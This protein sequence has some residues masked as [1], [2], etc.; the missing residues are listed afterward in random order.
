MNSSLRTI[1]VVNVRWHNATAWYGL[2]LARLLTNAGHKTL[3]LGL[4]NTESYGR[5][6]DLGLSPTA[7]PLNTA[8]PLELIAL[9]H[10][11]SALLSTF[12][13]HI[14]NC[15]RGENFFLWGLLKQSHSF[16]LVRTRGDQRLPRNTLPNRLLHQR[17]ADAL[18]ATNSRMATHFATALQVEPSH[19]HTIYGGVDT[20]HFAFD[21]AARERIRAQYNYGPNDHVVGLLGRF[22]EVKGQR[23]LIAAIAPLIHQNLPIHVLLIGFPTA[24]SQQAV[25]GWIAEANLGH[26]VRITGKVADVPAH[27]AALDTGVVASLWSET[28]ARAALEIMAARRP[29]ISTSVGVM[30]D[31]L[32]PEALCP[33]ADVPALTALVRRAVESP[34]WAQNLVEE[35][36]LRMK[37]LDSQ[38]FLQQTMSVY[39]KIQGSAD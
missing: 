2:E 6:Q 28:I 22:D 9:Y 11:L 26:R 16:K 10:R 20:S 27:L 4:P 21:P 35:Q 14:V 39:E 3:V 24:T 1:Q 15:H 12:K 36:N 13:P 23:E 33:P 8:N 17:V 7:L 18:V 25:E 5:A 34:E 37:T 29:L 19:I 32:T 38:S 31:L 30:P